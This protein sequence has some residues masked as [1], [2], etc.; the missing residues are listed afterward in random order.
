[1]EEKVNEENALLKSILSQIVQQV[2]VDFINNKGEAT[3]VNI[4]ENAVRYTL[5][6]KP[7]P[8]STKSCLSPREEEIVRLIGKGMGNKEIAEV[9]DI[10]KWTVATHLRR[11]FNKLDVGSRAAMIAKVMNEDLISGESSTN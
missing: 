3:V 9:L 2:D 11:V 10:S 8:K 1:M 4:E 7:I 6:C 5:T